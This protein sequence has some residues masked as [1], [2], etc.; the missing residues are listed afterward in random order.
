LRRGRIARWR[1]PGEA[2]SDRDVLRR[3]N[4]DIVRREGGRL[5]GATRR[6]LLGKP[7]Q[8]AAIGGLGMLGGEAPQAGFVDESLG[9]RDFLGASDEESLP[10]LDRSHELGRLE[11]R[12][13]TAGI[14]PGKT[15]AEPFY[16]EQAKLEIAPVDIGDLQ[17][18]ARMGSSR[19]RCRGPYC[20]RNRAR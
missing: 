12:V 13:M 14:E 19:R 10:V 4:L 20:R 7:V 15:A 8:I 2:L 6:R 9:E 16:V 1:D 3:T 17:F 11:Q 5:H 18:A